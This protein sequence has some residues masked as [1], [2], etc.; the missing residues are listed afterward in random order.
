MKAHAFGDLNEL[1]LKLYVTLHVLP[2]HWGAIQL[3][4]IKSELNICAQKLGPSNL[5]SGSSSS[6]SDTQLVPNQTRLQLGD[7]HSCT[8]NGH[9]GHGLPNST[10]TNSPRWVVPTAS[11][12]SALHQSFILATELPPSLYRNP[13]PMVTTNTIITKPNSSSGFICPKFLLHIWQLGISFILRIPPPS[14]KTLPSRISPFCRVLTSSSSPWIRWPFLGNWRLEPCFHTRL[15]K[16]FD[17]SIWLSWGHR[18]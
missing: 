8:M 10:D 15:K 17:E 9:Q 6:Y 11:S 2:P 13:I 18:P 4:R 7:F 14:L 5:H 16:G 1:N 3:W 12:S